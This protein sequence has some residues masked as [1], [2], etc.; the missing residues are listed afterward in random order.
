MSKLEQKNARYTLME[1]LEKGRE[2]RSI[3]RSVGMR[4]SALQ[5]FYR[6][7]AGSD[8]T[9]KEIEKLDILLWRML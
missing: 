8:L 4:T 9:P 6:A 3:A 5:S 2:Y 1:L 7:E